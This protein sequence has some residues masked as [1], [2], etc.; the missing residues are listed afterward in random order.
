[1]VRLGLAAVIAFIAPAVASADW[2]STTWNAQSGVFFKYKIGANYQTTQLGSFFNTYKTG[3]VLN[4]GS[5]IYSAISYCASLDEVNA[6]N[7]YFVQQSTITSEFAGNPA[8]RQKL[9]YLLNFGETFLTGLGFT[10]TQANSI[11]Q[12]A[13]W[14]LVVPPTVLDY[15]IVDGGGSILASWNNALNSL[16][17]NANAHIGFDSN[18]AYWR[19]LPYPDSPNQDM[20]NRVGNPGGGQEPDPV[21]LPPSALGAMLLTGIFAVGGR[22]LFGV[23]A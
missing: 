7:S 2:V 15:D 18:D 12:G 19:G 10:S 4:A 14:A 23:F 11:L 3:N 9:A 5:L 22:K 8:L 17:T 1:M 13:I 20:I 21:P 6:S 16:I